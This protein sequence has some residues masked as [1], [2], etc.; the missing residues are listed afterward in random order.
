MAG[1]SILIVSPTKSSNLGIIFAKTSFH[2]VIGTITF[3]RK[4]PISSLLTI[5]QGRVLLISFDQHY[6]AKFHLYA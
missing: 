6:T 4:V 2:P 3:K 5:I 1:L